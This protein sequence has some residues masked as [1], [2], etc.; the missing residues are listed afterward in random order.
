VPVKKLIILKFNEIYDCKYG[1]ITNY[2]P[3]P[4]LLLLLLDPRSGLEKIRIRD[5][6]PD[7]ATLLVTLL[8]DKFLFTLKFS[9]KSLLS[10]KTA[11]FYKLKKLS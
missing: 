5:K 10:S 1:K 2:F 9:E 8:Q 11:N 3:P 6:H 7:S 4:L